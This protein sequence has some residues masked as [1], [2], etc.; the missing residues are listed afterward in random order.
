MK[1]EAYIGEDGCKN[2]RCVNIQ[3]IACQNKGGYCISSGTPC[4]EGFAQSEALGCPAVTSSA[5]TTGAERKAYC[6]LPSTPIIK[7]PEC[8]KIG[9]NDEGWY[10]GGKLIKLEKCGC[11]AQCKETGSEKEGYY[12]SCTGGLIVYAQ[13]PDREKIDETLTGQVPVPQEAVEVTIDGRP[14]SVEQDFENGVVRIRSQEEAI[15]KEK[16]RISDGSIKVVT[17]EGTTELTHM[18]EDA[19]QAAIDSGTIYRINR[20]E[21]VNENGRPVYQ[22]DGS[23]SYR[24]LWI[25][26]AS[27]AATVM[28]DAGTN[29]VLPSPAQG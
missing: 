19:S 13:C 28:V 16:L 9:T 6:C 17:P 15:T 3:E 22:V 21:L 14:V 5:G 25:I 11:V 23:Q 26:P 10:S 29:E 27:R 1:L 4:R 8:A 24:I 20:I 7:T 12:N 2:W 18:P